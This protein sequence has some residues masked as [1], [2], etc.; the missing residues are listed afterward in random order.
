MKKVLVT[1]VDGFTGKHLGNALKLS[2]FKVIGLSDQSTDADDVFTCDLLDKESLQQIV[3]EVNPDYVIHLAAISFVGH[4]NADDFYRINVLGTVNLLEALLKL[5]KKPVKVLIASSANV[6]GNCD[7]SPILETQQ[8]LPVNHYAMSKLATEFMA[9]TYLDRLPLFFTRPFNYIGLGQAESFVIPKLISHFTKKAEVIELGNLNVEREFNDVR[10]VCD[11]Y[12][13][14]LDA[15][16]PG[17]TYNIC[18]GKPVTLSAMIALLTKMTGHS[19]NIKVNP[20]FVRENEV[21]QLFGNPEKLLHTI[22][23]IQQPILK[24]TLTWMLDR[25]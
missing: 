8:P 24:E 9:R 5:E 15:A 3:T 6:Y 19:I 16:K 12:L 2:G 21:H 10:F 1:G 11:A 23:A 18:S 7:K 17:E 13:K 25:S 20:A 4:G 22:G 14:L